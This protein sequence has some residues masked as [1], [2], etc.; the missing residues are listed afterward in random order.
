MK[1]PAI[2]DT[3]EPEFALSESH[4][5]MRYLSRK[6]CKNAPYLYPV[7]NVVKIAKID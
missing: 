7:D 6:Y 3:D 2:E 5:I 1:V 4:A